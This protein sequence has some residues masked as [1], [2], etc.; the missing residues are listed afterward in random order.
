MIDHYT[1]LC[2]LKTYGLQY[3]SLKLIEN[4]LTNRI[5]YC[6]YKGTRS[7]NLPVSKGVPQGS[8][9]GPLFF[10]IYINDITK[11]SDKFKFLMYADDTTLH[12]TLDNFMINNGNDIDTISTGIN[13]ELKLILA[14]LDKNRLIINSAKTKMTIFHMPQKIVAYPKIEINNVH[15]E[16]VDDFKFLGITII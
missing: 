9:L 10:S 12:G 14:W 13:A 4:Y 15:V 16:I 1:L 8:I 5:Q 11:S 3:T 6:D 2:K 7:S